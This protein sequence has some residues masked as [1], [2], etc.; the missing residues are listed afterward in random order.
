MK[1]V[2][3]RRDSSTAASMAYTSV[4]DIARS[5]SHCWPARRTGAGIGAMKA[6]SR[7][8]ICSAIGKSLRVSTDVSGHALFG[9]IKTIHRQPV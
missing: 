7:K 3:S 4:S 9:T 5:S 8:A 6:L 2:K 1:P